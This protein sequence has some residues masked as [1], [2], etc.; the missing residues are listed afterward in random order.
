MQDDAA[1]SMT[2]GAS[3]GASGTTDSTIVTYLVQM[4][5]ANLVVPQEN[6]EGFA[7]I[8]YQSMMNLANLA[9]GKGVPDPR[10]IVD[11]LLPEAGEEEEETKVGAVE[12][13]K[14]EDGAEGKDEGGKA[15]GKAAESGGGGAGEGA[16]ASGAEVA[17][18]VTVEEMMAAVKEE[19]TNA[20]AAPPPPKPKP[21]P[22]PAAT[23]NKNTGG[24]FK[25]TAK[26]GSGQ[27]VHPV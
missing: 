18:G 16:T 6:L 13:E 4:N 10:T 20:A 17:A 15:G 25:L 23:S 26:R 5:P 22:K 19:A 24:F 9:T 1:G 11:A 14:G 3:G 8:F 7:F 27:R 12:E 2:G 21:T